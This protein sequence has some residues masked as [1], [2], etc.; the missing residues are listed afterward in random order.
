MVPQDPKK[1]R[2]A[3]LTYLIYGLIYWGGGFYLIE[4]GISRQSGVAWFIVGGLFILLF[5][6]LIWHGARR[7]T[8]TWFTRLLAVFVLIRVFG[9]ARVILNDEGTAVPLPW[10]GAM[11]LAYGAV[12]FLLIAAGTCY[13]LARAG[14]NIGGRASTS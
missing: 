6:P 11:P 14:W 2:Q 4:T 13:M 7:K 3:A 5:P 10:G 8:L 9:L 1:Y 12:V